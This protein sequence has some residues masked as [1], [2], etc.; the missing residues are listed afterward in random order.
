MNLRIVLFCLLGGLCFT[1]SAIGAGHFGWYLLSGIVIAAAIY[2][3]VRF[4]PRHPLAQFGAIVLVLL[5]IG[6]FCTMSEGALFYPEMRPQMTVSLL[7][8]TATYV[9]AAAVLAG[10]AKWLKLTDPEARPISHRSPVK[11]TLLVLLSAFLYLVYY[12]V[13]GGL[14]YQFF[15]RQYYPH[16]AEQAM[17]LGIWFP[18]YQLMRGIAMTLAALPVIYALRL[19]RWQAAITVGL[20]IWVVGGAAPLLV[21]NATMVTAQRYIHIGEIFTQNFSLGVT[22]LLLLR[23]RA[24][25]LSAKTTSVAVV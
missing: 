24:A 9:L 5:V 18:I 16:A 12:E 15:T 2:P 6:L 11:A 19:P 14:T 25:K 20:L 3:V 21:P 13:F 10:L 1:V 7:R 23:P 8:G 4:G 17:A 22:A